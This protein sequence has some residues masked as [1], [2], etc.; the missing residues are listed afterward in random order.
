MKR[1]RVS[2]CKS[3]TEARQF[4]RSKQS[5]LRHIFFNRDS[6]YKTRKIEHNPVNNVQGRH[7]RGARVALATLTFLKSPLKFT[8]FNSRFKILFIIHSPKKNFSYPTNFSYPM[9]NDEMAP[10]VFVD[11]SRTYK[12]HFIMFLFKVIFN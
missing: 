12:P 1:L 10:L 5:F 7:F 11:P 9:K 3:S 8:L 4:S 2:Q 6:F